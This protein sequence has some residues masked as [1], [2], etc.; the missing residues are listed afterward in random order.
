MAELFPTVDNP[1]FQMQDNTVMNK[2]FAKGE[3][4]NGLKLK[5]EVED[6]D[7]RGK[8]EI[9]QQLQVG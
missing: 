8:A 9:L 4:Q 2:C 6:L 3:F 5:E 1:L 7:L